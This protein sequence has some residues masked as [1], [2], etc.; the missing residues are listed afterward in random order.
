MDFG[1]IPR[2]AFGRHAQHAED[3]TPG[4]LTTKAKA[5]RAIMF[6]EAKELLTALP[7]PGEAAHAI[8]TGHYDLCVLLAALLDLQPAPCRRLRIATLCFNR[9]NTV[10]L[11][12]L[13]ESGK[14]GGLTI[15]A[16]SFFKGHNK[17]LFETFRDELAAFPG[18]RIAAARS[19]AKLALY[20]FADGTGLVVEGSANLRTNNNAE[21]V[22][23]IHDRSLH[24]FYA[25]WVDDWTARH[26][27]DDGDDP[28]RGL[29]PSSAPCWMGRCRSRC[30][31]LWP[32]GRPPAKPR[33]RSRRA[34]SP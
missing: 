21:A 28:G 7:G 8:M 29:R 9:R 25:R 23:V 16:S 31:N 33:G 26:E 24:D 20:D 30:G 4:V 14:I 13:L 3:K 22:A 27:G 12:G 1:A 32:K 18:S 2:P 11:L 15:L 6:K 17:E 5:R 10:E 34:G 19:H